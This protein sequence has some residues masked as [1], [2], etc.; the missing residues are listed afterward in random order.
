MALEYD[1]V[2]L[3]ALHGQFRLLDWMRRERFLWDRQNCPNCY[4]IMRLERSKHFAKDKFCWRCPRHNC[5]TRRSVREGS[6]FANSNLSLRKQLLIAI[7]FATESSASSTAQ[8]LRIDRKSVQKIYGRIR[9]LYEA[10]LAR[11]PISFNDGYEYE[12]DELFFH[13]VRLPNGAHD[14]RWVAGI[15]ERQTGKVMYYKVEDRSAYSLLPPIVIAV[16]RGSFVYTDEW[17]SYNNLHLVGFHH[18]HVNHSADEYQ[19][20][21][22]VGPIWLDVH[23]NTLE[24]YNRVCRAKFRNKQRIS[25]E[26]LDLYLSEVVYRKSGRSL[27]SPIKV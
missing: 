24:G 27:F 15:L 22:Q 7:N 17:H 1:E 11:T 23:I 8:R 14:T 6:F 16:P 12:V 9:R 3:E 25:V 21:D 10:D 5:R 26:R 2:D 4:E 20:W 18:H 13:H 19:R